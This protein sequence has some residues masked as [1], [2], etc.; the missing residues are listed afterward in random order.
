MCSALLEA[1]DSGTIR[2]HGLDLLSLDKVE[3]MLFRPRIQI[4]FQDSAALPVRYTARRIIEEPLVIQ[5]RHSP[6]E[7]TAVALELMEKVG[8]STRMGNR[9]PNQLSGGQRQRLAIARSLTLEPDLLILDEPFVGLDLSI[10]GSIVN[11]LLDLQA[12]N[13][14]AYLYISHDLE[15]V[16]YFSDSVAV[17]DQGKIVEQASVSDLFRS[18][19][20]AHTRALL[21]YSDR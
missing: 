7:R 10:R 5:G 14:L 12:D 8:A 18:P 13:S 16:Q 6:K 2:F 11:L 21:A 9:L 15:L 19:E 3:R 17:M 1:P 20:H 4:I